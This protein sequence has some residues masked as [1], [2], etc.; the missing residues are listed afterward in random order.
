[1]VRR[2]KE[3]YY[4]GKRRTKGRKDGFNMLP[5]LLHRPN[6]TLGDQQPVQRRYRYF[7]L[8]GSC[9]RSLGPSWRGTGAVTTRSCT[10]GFPR[11]PRAYPPRSGK[12][13][14]QNDEQAG[15]R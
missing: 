11:L 12:A 10:A 4:V 6:Q 5:P 7:V 8:C 14:L 13:L 3:I 15:V 2:S 1:M 9:V